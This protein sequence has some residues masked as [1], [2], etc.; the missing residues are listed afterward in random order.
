MKIQLASDLHLEF[1]PNFRLKNTGAQV[2][3]ISG[4][5]CVA[6]YV[7]RKEPSPYAARSAQALAFFEAAAEEFPYIIYIMGNHEHYYGEFNKTATIMKEWLAHIPN[8]FILD[9]EL[10]KIGDTTFIGST[11][12]T[13]CA[14]RNPIILNY[15]S[16]YLNDFKLITYNKEPFSKFLPITSAIEHTKSLNFLKTSISDTEGKIVVMTHHAPSRLSVN[17]KYRFETSGNH[18][19]YTDLDVFIADNPSISLWTHGH[20]HDNA[21]YTIGNT[22]VLCNPRGYKGENV[23][24]NP[25]LIIEV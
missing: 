22:R 16:G 23:H 10:I 4:D 20:M 7:T 9:N 14:D 5:A 19:Y 18:A 2:L 25:Q 3:L 6:D 15:L 1:E 12:W 11:L 8:I 17:P 21:D 24:F 13:S